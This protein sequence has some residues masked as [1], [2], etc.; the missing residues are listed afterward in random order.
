M[1]FGFVFAK[2][3]DEHIVNDVSFITTG[4]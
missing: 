1:V 4:L 2:K 3:F